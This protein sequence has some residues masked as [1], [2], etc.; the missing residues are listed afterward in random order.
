MEGHT[1]KGLETSLCN[2]GG[3]ERGWWSPFDPHHHHRTPLTSKDL[4]G[5]QT[6]LPFPCQVETARLCTKGHNA[7]ESNL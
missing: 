3:R 2:L 4:S 5:D 1:A 6:M 7:C